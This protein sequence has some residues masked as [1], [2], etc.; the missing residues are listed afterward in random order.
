MGKQKTDLIQG[1]LDLRVLNIL[2]LGSIHGWDITQR[3]QQISGDVLRANQGSLYPVLHRL[4][5]QGWIT[6]EWGESENSRLARYYK[7][8]VAGRRQ[9]AEEHET[10]ARFYGA[11]ERILQTT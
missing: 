7:L 1:T 5:A 8:T 6:A 9:L 3:I 10:W 2:A 4:E 11:I